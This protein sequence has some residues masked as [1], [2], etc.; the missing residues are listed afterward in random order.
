MIREVL[1]HLVEQRPSALELCD[2]LIA[3]EVNLG[4]G[5]GISSL[6]CFQRLLKTSNNS[7]FVVTWSVW[8]ITIL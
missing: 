6:C 5:V 3:V 4:I 8:S 7:Q 2:V 1:V